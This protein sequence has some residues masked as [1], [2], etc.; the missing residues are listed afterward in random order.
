LFNVSFK[1]ADSGHDRKQALDEPFI[2][3]TKDFG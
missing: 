2:S 3:G 1:L